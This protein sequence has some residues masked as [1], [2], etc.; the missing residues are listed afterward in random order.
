MIAKST[1]MQTTRLNVKL[2]A[3]SGFLAYNDLA[4]EGMIYN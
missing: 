3:L 2:E 1:Q 4:Q